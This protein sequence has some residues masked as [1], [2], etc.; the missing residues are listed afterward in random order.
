MRFQKKKK[1]RTVF[2]GEMMKAVF[3]TVNS[4]NGYTDILD[5]ETTETRTVVRHTLYSAYILYGKKTN[6]GHCTLYIRCTHINAYGGRR[7]RQLTERRF[8]P[9][10]RRHIILVCGAF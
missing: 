9:A 3:I 10:D 4:V 6:S 1:N 8:L 7:R 5:H 2:V